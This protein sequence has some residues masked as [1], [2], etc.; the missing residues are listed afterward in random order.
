[1]AHGQNPDAV[2]CYCNLATL[3]CL[4]FVYG[5]FC[6]TTVKLSSCDRDLMAHKAAI[7]TIWPLQNHLLT[8][9]IK[10]QY[11]KSLSSLYGIQQ[12]LGKNSFHPVL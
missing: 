8:S 10:G 2:K 3:I 9:L 1:M 6:S 5:C 12:M 7:F 11:E 4:H